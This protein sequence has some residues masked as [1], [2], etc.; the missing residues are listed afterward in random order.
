M[1]LIQVTNSGRN[2][3]MASDLLRVADM[4]HRPV[5]FCLWRDIYLASTDRRCRS[6][7]SCGLL[8]HS[9]RHIATYR[10]TV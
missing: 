6:H 1:K 9:G 7:D 2:D 5:F 8:D 4:L 3:A 10:S